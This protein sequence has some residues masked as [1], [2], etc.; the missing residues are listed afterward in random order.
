MDVARPAVGRWSRWVAVALVL[1]AL[2]AACEPPADSADAGAATA[3]D[4]D[5]P[6]ATPTVPQT[7]SCGGGSCECPTAEPC[8]MTCTGF[9]NA[10]CGDS[11][12]CELFCA[13]GQ[14]RLQ[15]SPG[16]S[17]SLAC[18]LGGCVVDCPAGAICLSTCPGGSCPC[19]GAGCAR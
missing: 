9:C 13:Q 15:C 17:C 12:A 4:T 1:I 7:V 10:S 8:A 11:S 2:F 14:C 19:T 3:V 18:P 16:T 6:N 5:E